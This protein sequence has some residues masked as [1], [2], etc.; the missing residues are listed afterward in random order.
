[1]RFARLI[2]FGFVVGFLFLLPS[3]ATALGC[4]QCN[5]QYDACI[6]DAEGDYDW[7]LGGCQRNPY[8]GCSNWCGDTY[9]AD[10]NACLAVYYECTDICD[11]EVDRPRE[12]CPIVLD[13]GKRGWRFTSAEKGVL[14]DIDG[15]GDRDAVAWTDPEAESSFL[16]WDRNLNGLIDSGQEL[17]GDATTQPPSGAPNGFLALALLDQVEGG[18]NGDGVISS[19]DGLWGALQLWVDRNHNGISEG[20][21]LASLESRKILAIDLAYRESRRRDQHGNELR[22]RSKVVLEDGP[23][24]HAV[25]VFF[26]RLP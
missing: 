13:L 11:R 21:E 17:F 2:V 18:G 14:F 15:D 26:Q 12:N 16:V 5:F 22:F 19:Q 20:S 10:L 3:V 7:C 23:D 24:T 1:M 4:Y 8:S 25:D 6:Y 9:Q